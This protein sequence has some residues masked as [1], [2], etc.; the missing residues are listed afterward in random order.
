M[1][2]N[3][4]KKRFTSF[5][6][7]VIRGLIFLGAPA[8]TIWVL[9]FL[10]AKADGF[11]GGVVR[12]F[13][14]W[15]LSDSAM[16][17][18]VVGF[19][20]PYVS[21]VLLMLIAAMVGIVASFQIGKRGLKL[22]DQL[23]LLFPGVSRI[24]KSVRKVLNLLGDHNETPKFSRTVLFKLDGRYPEIGFVANEFMVGDERHL[25]VF[26]PIQTP[27][28]LGGRIPIVPEKDTIPT[29]LSVEESIQFLMSMGAATPEPL[30]EAF[31]QFKLKAA[32]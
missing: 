11:V 12:Y 21:L 29:G 5:T 15:L 4:V 31:R 10:A 7:L 27:N 18:D 23:I 9:N 17:S 20:L 1:Q 30:Q 14:S 8:L 24:Y 28:P 16:Q 26:N 22:I 13:A 6:G 3:S 32:D 2:E 19:V 25:V